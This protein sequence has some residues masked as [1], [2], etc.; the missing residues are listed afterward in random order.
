VIS[1]IKILK[2]KVIE[3]AYT[4]FLNGI[5]K[6]EE[7][8]YYNSH[9]IEKKLENSV[10]YNSNS[11]AS[12]NNDETLWGYD[13]YICGTNLYDSNIII[14]CNNYYCK[15]C[16][17][18]YIKK[19]NPKFINKR[20]DYNKY[21]IRCPGYYCEY[22]HI[23]INKVMTKNEYNKLGNIIVHKVTQCNIPDC[24]G[25]LNGINCQKC[26]Q[27]VCLH[28]GENKHEDKCKKEHIK[29]IYK[30]IELA[31]QDV[32]ICPRCDN[33]IF[34]NDGCDSMFCWYCSTIF[35]WVT[36]EIEKEFSFSGNSYY[37]KFKQHYN[38][39]GMYV[40]L[41]DFNIENDLEEQYFQE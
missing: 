24:G 35:N 15:E 37:N 5:V 19:K 23:D 27:Q 2:E 26:N 41:E 33:L 11:K 1:I 17:A 20:F 16:I 34:R 13:C 9:V 36:G 7:K 39:T 12:E 32:E 22:N 6:S 4:M 18:E 3:K 30:M 8:Q 29:N 31:G 10:E 21:K 25:K 28:C 14:G 40:R 38:E